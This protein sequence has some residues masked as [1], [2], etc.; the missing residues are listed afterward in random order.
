MKL[1]EDRIRKDGVVLGADVLKVDNFLNHQV[2]PDLMLAV[3][4]EFYNQFK[5]SKITKILTVESSGIAPALAT[6]MSFHVPLVF[7]RKH[8]S[9]T[10]KDDMFTATVY[11]FTKQTSN[12]IAIAKKFLSADDK[13]LII[14]DFLANGQ[15]VQG[16]TDIIKQAGAET[17]GAGIVIEKTFQKG[18]KMFDDQGVRVV[19]LARIAAFEDGQVVFAD[20][21]DA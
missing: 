7:A 9:L 14:D 18:R 11:S 21:Q 16:L 15:A 5:D 12:T 8:K 10:L 6:A 4:K 1:L 3:G 17:V 19:S 2:D 13:V 20:E